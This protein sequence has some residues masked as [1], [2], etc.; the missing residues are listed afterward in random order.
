MIKTQP[1]KERNAIVSD[2]TKS[3][4]E[5]ADKDAEHNHALDDTQAV[6]REQIKRSTLT[7]AAAI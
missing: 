1:A 3:E 2:T 5:Q 7:H 4:F 6:I